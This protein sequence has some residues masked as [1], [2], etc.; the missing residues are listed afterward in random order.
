MTRIPKASA[1]RQTSCPIPP[2]PITPS[3]AS[4]PNYSI[5]YTNGVLTVTGS[6]DGTGSPPGALERLIETQLAA[7]VAELNASGSVVDRAQ[8][9]RRLLD[10]LGV[11][12]LPI[13]SELFSLLQREIV[14]VTD[15]AIRMPGSSQK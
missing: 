4:A 13:Q 7:V 1:R 6:T 11:K 3:G 12:S 15:P 14:R 2:Y 10:R 5:S 8:V 9:E